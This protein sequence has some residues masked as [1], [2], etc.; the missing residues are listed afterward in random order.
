MVLH[1]L[2]WP[3]PAGTS[4]LMMSGFAALAP[5]WPGSI[6]TILLPLIGPRAGAGSRVSG[7]GGGAGDSDVVSGS[8]VSGAGGGS[9]GSTGSEVVGVGSE[10]GL[11]VGVGVARR[12]VGAAFEEEATAELSPGAVTSG[13]DGAAAEELATA[14]SVGG[15]A[16]V[17]AGAQEASRTAHAA[18]AASAALPAREAGR[19]A[20][21]CPLCH[22]WAC[23]LR[24]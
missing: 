21:I 13:R 4:A 22:R 14:A 16:L 20:V 15:V 17:D 12:V 18:V 11:G 2:V 5:L 9:G 8:V 10:V 6:T 1:G 23:R 7:V 24:T 3:N 19:R